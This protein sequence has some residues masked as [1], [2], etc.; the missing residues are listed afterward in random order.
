MS[1]VSRHEGVMQFTKC[2]DK[3]LLPIPT[4][5][6]PDLSALMSTV[7]RHVG[8]GAALSVIEDRIH[9][10]LIVDDAR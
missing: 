1:R 8:I 6:L 9:R 3:Q 7:H 5:V 2:D 4:S 10:S